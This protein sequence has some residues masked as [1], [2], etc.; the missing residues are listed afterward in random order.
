MIGVSVPLYVIDSKTLVDTIEA[1]PMAEEIVYLDGKIWIMNESA[2]NKYIFG[3]F[4]TGNTLFSVN[5]PFPKD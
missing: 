5:Y 2:S 4:T 1:P 3:K